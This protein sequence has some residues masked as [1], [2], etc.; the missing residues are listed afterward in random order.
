MSTACSE[1]QSSSR[2]ARL[3]ETVLAVCNYLNGGSRNGQALGFEIAFLPSLV[4]TKTTDNRTS[5]L[6]VISGRLS[7]DVTKF[8]EDFAHL[9]Q[10]CRASIETVA[11]NIGS[12][13]VGLR[14][15]SNFLD[16]FT[17]ASG[18]DKYKETMSDFLVTAKGEF[19]LLETMHKKMDTVIKDLAR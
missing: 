11:K 12:L 16:S 10:A 2:F 9:D 4:D 19:A 15:L 5:L 6:H 8:T 1:V 17:P 3:L 14:E 18:K 13:R 7:L